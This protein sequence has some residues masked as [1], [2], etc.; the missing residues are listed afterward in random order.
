MLVGSIAAL[1][2][3]AFWTIMV[4]N[5]TVILSKEFSEVKNHLEELVAKN[6][7]LKNDS[8]SAIDTK[9]LHNIARE[10]GLVK[11]EN[12]EYLETDL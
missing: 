9:S 6:A 8:Y 5:Q 2:G 1:L 12:P 10:F 4:Y 7:E 3:V 11:V